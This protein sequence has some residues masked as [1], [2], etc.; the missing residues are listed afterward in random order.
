MASLEKAAARAGNE[1]RER[2]VVTR[3]PSRCHSVTSLP[4][5]PGLAAGD[6]GGGGFECDIV[7]CGWGRDSEREW[8]LSAILKR[9]FTGCGE[10]HSL[11]GKRQCVEAEGGSSLAMIE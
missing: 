8:R 10:V 2:S 9:C 5:G 1:T 6:D 7:G 4:G 3:K 11:L